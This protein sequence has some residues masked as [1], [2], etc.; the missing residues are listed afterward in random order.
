M[1]F[2][3]GGANSI[4]KSSIYAQKLNTVLYK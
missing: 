3:R 2:M 1:P 4:R